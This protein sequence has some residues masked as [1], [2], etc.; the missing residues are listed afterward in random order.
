MAAR[1]CDLGPAQVLLGLVHQFD[2]NVTPAAE[3]LLDHLFTIA[4]HATGIDVTLKRL[5]GFLAEKTRL[6]GFA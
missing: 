6:N 5:I 1:Q 2:G 4:E 3:Q